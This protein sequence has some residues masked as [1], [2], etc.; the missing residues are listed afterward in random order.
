[1]RRLALLVA[2]L[3][4]PALH[5]APPA[6]FH[7]KVD[8]F[9]YPEAAVKVAVI[10]NPIAGFDAPDPYL[11]P[12]ALE[13]RRFGDDSLAFSGAVTS[14]RG[15][16]THAQSGDQVWWFDFSAL[17]APGSYYVFDPASGR[18][19]ARFDIGD[20]V[21][22]GVLR[23]A[24]RSFYYQRCGSARDAV[25][26]G[27]SWADAACH[28]GPAQDRD[29]RAVL[30]PT[31]ASARDLSGGWHDA[32]DYNKYVN[33]ADAPVHDL[34]L[35]FEEH[36]AV[37]GDDTGIPESGNCVPD[38]LDELRWELDWFLRMQEP[39]GSVLHKVSVIDFSGASPPSADAGPRRWA[40]ATAS[41]TIS[42]AG[43][44]AHAAIVYR[45]QADPAL[46]AYATALETA[47]LAAWDWLAANPGRIPSSYDNQGF[48]NSSAEDDA[49]Q[50]ATNRVCAASY[51]FALTS[52]PRFRSH[53]DLNYD[54]VH[55]LQ[56]GYAYPF[57]MEYQD[58]L[59][60]YTQTAGATAAVAADITA[61]Y[62]DSMRA[63]SLAPH[64]AGDDAYRA[65]LGDTDYTW[66]SSR[67]KSA[68]GSMFLDVVRHGLDPGAEAEYTAAAATYLHYMHGVN[69]LATV[70]LSNMNASGAERSV[71]EFYHSWFAD[72]SDWDNAVTSRFGPAPGF[73]PGGA[74][75]SFR[76][77]PAYGGPPIAPPENQPIQKSYASW[78]TSW[79][80]NSWEV[81]E[82]AIGYQGA[83]VR[84]LAAFAAAAAAPS[85]PPE[86]PLNALRAVRRGADV[87]LSWP[88]LARATSYGVL[89]CDAS[90]G[91]CTPA[92]HAAVTTPGFL[93]PT[94]GA[95]KLW[96]EI[97]SRN[98]CGTSR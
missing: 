38:L 43:A 82:N 27:A 5:A 18:G 44:C 94:P 98:A 15:G 79:P 4:A 31:A 12:A 2:L 54:A 30:D 85:A 23:Q 76:P 86:A 50:Q 77:D 81:T 29:C 25:H 37:W 90:A 63:D 10:A 89:R 73:V 95:A 64:R 84:L 80:E 42:A 8:Q 83:Y 21:Y 16:M 88:A 40:E 91:P 13:V 35:A 45:Q 1:M 87:E 3:L 49:Y 58:C 36:P 56:W 53:V 55:L 28:T 97:E 33:F 26:A 60:Y 32:G 66:G 41:A 75:P 78:N 59:L 72:G 71:D 62:R 14:W 67:T 22:D 51:L 96:Y 52:D 47:A 11:P 69:P 70:Y 46:Q 24:M 65:W 93:D 74:N 61:A 19:S 7:F 9:G 6:D 57:E 68:L 48:V 34:L 17:Q 39:D 20:A 92:A